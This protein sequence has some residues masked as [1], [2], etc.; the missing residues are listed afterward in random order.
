MSG[1]DFEE[2]LEALSPLIDDIL[3]KAIGENLAGKGR[4]V[5]L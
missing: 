4:D 1:N 5:D 3:S 2:P